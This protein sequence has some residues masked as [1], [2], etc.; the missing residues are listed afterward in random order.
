MTVPVQRGDLVFA[1]SF[2]GEIAPRQSHPILVPE[3]RNIWQVTVESVLADGTL[4]KQG[5][6]VLTFAKGALEEDLRDRDA[7]RA[8]WLHRDT[9][10]P[11]RDQGRAGARGYEGAA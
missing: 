7:Q 1:S 2:Y 11:Q 4:V 5:D 8:D 6:V 3:L 9:R 10:H